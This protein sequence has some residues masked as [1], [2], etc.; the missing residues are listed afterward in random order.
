VGQQA[1]PGSRRYR[2]RSALVHRSR[3]PGLPWP[4]APLR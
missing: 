1:V 4:S 3:G 2:P